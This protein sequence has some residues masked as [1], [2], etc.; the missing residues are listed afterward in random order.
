MRGA[1]ISDLREERLGGLFAGDWASDGDEFAFFDFFLKRYCFF[2]CGEFA[3]P[4]AA[5]GGYHLFSGRG[6]G[7][8]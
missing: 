4:A 5:G 1:G 8:K 7:E 3:S 6:G 2:D